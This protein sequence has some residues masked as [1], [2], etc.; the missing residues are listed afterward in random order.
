[1]ICEICGKE[2]KLSPVLVEGSKV[3][4]CKNCETAGVKQRF[5]KKKTS[6]STMSR[7]Q[8]ILI[9]NYNQIIKEARQKKG[10]SQEK[11]A[12]NLNE[13][14]SL[15]QNIESAK[16]RPSSDLIKKLQAYLDVNLLEEYKEYEYEKKESGKL[17][18]GDLIKIKKK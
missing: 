3:M 12:K 9:Q 8:E 4:A 18:L 1:M 15:I 10:L 11:L 17:T 13:K 2:A 16:I 7:P 14:E 5:V 6:R